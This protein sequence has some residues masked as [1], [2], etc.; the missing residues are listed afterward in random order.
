MTK[1]GHTSITPTDFDPQT[2]SFWVNFD[3]P[4]NVTV[5]SYEPKYFEFQEEIKD[6]D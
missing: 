1:F 5:V 3:L 6:N 4:P 2:G